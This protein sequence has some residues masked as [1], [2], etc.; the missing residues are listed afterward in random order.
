MPARAYLRTS[1]RIGYQPHTSPIECITSSIESRISPPPSPSSIEC[2]TS[3]TAITITNTIK[4]SHPQPFISQ[5][6]LFASAQ[7]HAFFQQ[8]PPHLLL[9]PETPAHGG[10]QNRELSTAMSH[11]KCPTTM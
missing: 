11:A 9:S 6:L 10:Y 1:G 3:A 5:V 2:I 8:W 7:Q 4:Q